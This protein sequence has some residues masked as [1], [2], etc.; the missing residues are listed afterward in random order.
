MFSHNVIDVLVFAAPVVLTLAACVFSA[1]HER[2]ECDSESSVNSIEPCS[3]EPDRPARV[4]GRP[5]TGHWLPSS[6]WHF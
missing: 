6:S 3:K 4:R 1:Y 5:R 2:E